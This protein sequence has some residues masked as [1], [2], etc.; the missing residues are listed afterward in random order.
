MRINTE[1][2][3][4]FESFDSDLKILE[5]E[6]MILSCDF[7]QIESFDTGSK[8]SKSKSKALGIVHSAYEC[9]KRLGNEFETSWLH[10]G[11]SQKY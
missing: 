5:S 6:L 1:Q 8:I 7:K 3:Q 2:N 11:Y 10:S 4:I 9:P